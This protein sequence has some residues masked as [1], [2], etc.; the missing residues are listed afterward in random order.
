MKLRSVR[1][2]TPDTGFDQ[3][4]RKEVR[5]RVRRKRYKNWFE[6]FMPKGKWRFALCLSSS[7]LVIVFVHLVDTRDG[8]P[9]NVQDNI[10]L[11]KS[12]FED[13]SIVDPDALPFPSDS[14]FLVEYQVEECSITA[15]FLDP[16]PASP[17]RSYPSWRFAL[18]SVGA[19]LPHACVAIMTTACPGE[20]TQELDVF[21]EETSAR[22]R[23]YEQAL[24]LLQD[25]M[26]SGRVRVS[27]I[28]WEVYGLKSCSDFGNPTPAMLS[29]NFWKDEFVEGDSETILI[30]QD[31]S[32][33]CK[34]IP[35]DFLR[36]SYAMVGAVWPREPTPLMPFP[37]EG[38]CHG[39]ANFW[40]SWLRPQLRWQRWVERGGGGKPVPKPRYLL[41]PTD[42]NNNTT[43]GLLLG[44][45]VCSDGRAPI[46]N[47]GF[48]LRRRS[49]MIKAIET[50]PHTK[51]NNEATLP[52]M[53]ASPCRVVDQVNEDFYFGVILRGLQAPLPLASEAARFSVEMMWPDQVDEMYGGGDDHSATVRRRRNTQETPVGMHKPWWYISN[54]DLMNLR[55]QCPYLQYIFKPSD[56]RVST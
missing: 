1:R 25:M 23:I 27:F 10:A 20:I 18:E 47:G 28:D 49:W 32:V 54:D 43:S 9:S 50:C 14:S 52:G 34:N 13:N 33:L 15:V 35:E 46:G 17:S 19:M 56:S 55:Y 40:K 41:E 38:M 53:D 30:I 2:R 7:I 16:R 24:P 31:D 12:V 22:Q 3:H 44:N 37:P 8:L 45:R 21:E 48:S 39:M 26:H 42:D 6:A 5:V 11:Y 4:R 36:S 51:Y 29:I